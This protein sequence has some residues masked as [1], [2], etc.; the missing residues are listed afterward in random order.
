MGPRQKTETN[1]GKCERVRQCWP[2]C[3]NVE[4]RSGRNAKGQQQ[5]MRTDVLHEKN[6]LEQTGQHGLVA[7]NGS[8]EDL[9]D[10][11]LGVA[12]GSAS[13][14]L[15]NLQLLLWFHNSSRRMAHGTHD[16]V[17]TQRLCRRLLTQH[18]PKEPSQRLGNAIC[19]LPL[20]KKPHARAD[21]KVL[22]TNENR[23]VQEFQTPFMRGFCRS[24]MVGRR[25]CLIQ[26]EKKGF[27]RMWRSGRG[28][29]DCCSG[30]SVKF[31][32][33]HQSFLLL[34]TCRHRGTVLFV[35]KHKKPVGHFN[36][37]MCSNSVSS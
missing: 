32:T 29:W 19:T 10:L 25:Q 18:L 34:S 3:A 12:R 9:D 33:T 26:T 13:D 20:S 17:G 27:W 16:L 22:P 36:C 14:L 28:K 35:G 11:Q 24:A 15:H 31:E 23:S 7:S 8:A 4:N 2:H 30:R 6:H 21:S 37:L 1:N 5:T